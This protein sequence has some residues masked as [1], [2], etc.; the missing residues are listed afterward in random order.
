VKDMVGAKVESLRILPPVDAYAHSHG[1]RSG[2][3]MKRIE[4]HATYGEVNRQSVTPE[5]L[6]SEQG[7]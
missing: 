1:Y 7:K 6:D 4:F 2:R 3:D 5:M